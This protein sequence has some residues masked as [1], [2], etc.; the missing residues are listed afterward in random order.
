MKK[1]T[2][3]L[4]YSVVVIFCLITTSK[5]S[6]PP[7]PLSSPFPLSRSSIGLLTAP[8]VA[9]GGGY[10]IAEYIINYQERNKD[11]RTLDVSNSFMLAAVATTYF[12]IGIGGLSLLGDQPSSSEYTL[13]ASAFLAGIFA[14]KYVQSIYKKWHLVTGR[15]VTQLIT[16]Q[17]QLAIAEQELTVMRQQ[18]RVMEEEFNT[19]KNKLTAYQNNLPTKT[20]THAE[21]EENCVICQNLLSDSSE[22]GYLIELKCKHL[23][24]Q[25]C[26]NPWVVRKIA[27][28]LCRTCLIETSGRITTN[29]EASSSSITNLE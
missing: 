13:Y 7:L 15:I 23:F 8:F 10:K 11:K 28:P 27:C 6:F 24:H 3:L 16:T 29:P 1:K 21:Q 20:I 14:E 9:F 22:N 5:A 26:I 12:S 25:H 18:N 4:K 19:Y 2:L 17:D